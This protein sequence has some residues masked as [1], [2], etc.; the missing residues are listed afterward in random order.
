LREELEKQANDLG[1]ERSVRFVGF[2]ANVQDWLAL[3]DV[4]VLPSFFEGLPLVAIESL[5]AQ[6]PMVATAVDGTAEVIVHEKTGLT[7]P[8]G[9][10]GQLAKAI[11]RL[12]EDAPLRAR[13]AA[14]GRQWTLQHFSEEQQIAKTQSLYLQAV[15]QL[16]APAQAL[17]ISGEPD[18]PA[19]ANR[20]G[21]E[22][23]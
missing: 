14:N 13:L 9:D 20:S 21:L 12:L 22:R 4:S 10:A 7:V 19:A 2:Q 16:G 23:R 5:A 15:R 1:V 3:A 18:A 17:E 11:V 6:R 8:P